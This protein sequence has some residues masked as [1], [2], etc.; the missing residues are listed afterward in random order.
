[1]LKPFV[2]T[3]TYCLANL[4]AGKTIVPEFVQRQATGENIGAYLVQLLRD[5]KKRETVREQ[6]KQA[7]DRLG[8]QDAYREAAKC[9]R[10]S[11]LE[12]QG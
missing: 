1:M 10:E 4:I 2:R 3:Q 11:F 6:L 12:K 5:E 8:R 9:L 7:A